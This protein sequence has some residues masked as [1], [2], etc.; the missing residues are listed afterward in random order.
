MTLV[1]IF[2]ILFFLATFLWLVLSPSKA[3]QKFHDHIDV[4]MSSQNWSK[5][6]PTPLLPIF[7]QL[8]YTSQASLLEGS[9]NE[10][11]F[12]LYECN[13]PVLQ[14]NGKNTQLKTVTLLSV[15][16]PQTFPDFIV[17]PVK[18]I[19]GI[20]YDK[21][22]QSTFGFMPL[23]LEGD[24][25]K[26]VRI[27]TQ[28]GQEIDVLTYISPDV[29]AVIQDNIQSFIILS[30]NYLSVSAYMPLNSESLDRMLNDTR[31]LLTEIRQ[32]PRSE[33]LANVLEEF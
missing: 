30:G 33:L 16:F 18:G 4:L 32:K 17:I 26:Y 25:S 6:T 11:K 22:M 29:M 10:Q 3:Q 12:W 5:A 20:A 19:M 21:M 31:L 13:P 24:F 14:H 1:F 28:Q 8:E 27:Y 23:Q 15:A 9:L 2:I 7:E